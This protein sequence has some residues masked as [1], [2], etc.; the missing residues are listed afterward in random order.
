MAFHL[1]HNQK[2]RLT[3]SLAGLFA[4]VGLVVFVRPAWDEFQVRQSELDALVEQLPPE[5]SRPESLGQ[6]IRRITRIRGSL[7]EQRARFP[8]SENIAQLLVELQGILSGTQVTRFYP[9]KLEEVHLTALASTDTKVLQQRIIVDAVGSFFD[10]RNFLAELERFKHPVQVRSFEIS[11]PN[12][13]EVTGQLAMKFTMAAFLLDHAPGGPEAERRALDDLLA[14]LHEEVN[15][16]PPEA[17]FPAEIPEVP[18]LAPRVLVPPLPRPP[19]VAQR[20]QPAAP[21]QLPTLPPRQPERIGGIHN[22]PANW[23]VLG[24]M[25]SKE[26][27]TAII[28]VGDSQLAVTRGD[29]VESGW[30]V[31]RI[32]PRRVVVRRDDVT[33]VLDFPE[34]AGKQPR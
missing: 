18:P 19:V 30:L 31:D 7:E 4:A 33:R 1:S 14:E 3:A 27:P 2:I 26:V 24:I 21:P 13:A 15:R 17:P 16:A 29:P 32:D 22:E 28:Q 11:E 12:E 8:I 6:L 25:F 23:R 5:R 34:G 20:P 9:T 10:L